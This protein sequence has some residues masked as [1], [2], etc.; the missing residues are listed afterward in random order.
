[1]KLISEA[2]LDDKFNAQMGKIQTAL[3]KLLDSTLEFGGDTKP[4][5]SQKSMIN[6]AIRD[7]E[8]IRAQM[9][10]E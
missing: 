6:Q 7:L 8:K 2:A 4:V 1:M 9:F 10:N 3:D 5:Q